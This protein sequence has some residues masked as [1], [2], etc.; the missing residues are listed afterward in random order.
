MALR[1][2]AGRH[3]AAVLSAMAGVNDHCYRNTLPGR[4]YLD[5]V[6]FTAIPQYGNQSGEKK[7]NSAVRMS[8]RFSIQMI[9]GNTPTE[10]MPVSLS[11]IPIIAVPAGEIKA[12]LLS[13]L[14]RIKWPE[15]T[16]CA[17][18]AIP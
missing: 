16:A 3:S 5:R 14:H 11:Y 6:G 9:T 7:Q 10:H 17:L 2:A 18:C 15:R 4:E 13:T 1:D 8:W 12:R